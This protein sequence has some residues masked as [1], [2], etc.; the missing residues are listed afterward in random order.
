MKNY[1]NKRQYDFISFISVCNEFLT[2]LEERLEG[3]GQ[4]KNLIYF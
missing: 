2:G 3:G 1:Q 4:D